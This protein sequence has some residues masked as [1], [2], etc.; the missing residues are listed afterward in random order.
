MKTKTT[1]CRVWFVSY[2]TSNILIIKSFV[3]LG[4]KLPLVNE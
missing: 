3:L 1:I 4:H 2:R